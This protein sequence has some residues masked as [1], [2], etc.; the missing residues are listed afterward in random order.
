M[1]QVLLERL[2]DRWLAG[3]FTDISAEPKS[4]QRQT[5]AVTSAIACA[6]LLVGVYVYLLLWHDSAISTHWLPDT[7]YIMN[8]AWT[9]H[10]G[11][12]PNIDFTD[13][14]G[15][16]LTRLL[17]LGMSLAGPSMK[18][19]DYTLA[20][21]LVGT[22]AMLAI[23]SFRRLLPMSAI[24]ALLIV[25]ALIVTRAPLEQPF[26]LKTASYATIYNRLAWVMLF[27]AYLVATVPRSRGND[28]AAL[29]VAGFATAVML[30]T[31]FSFVLGMPAIATAFLLRGARRD[32][33]VWIVAT[34]AS[35]LAFWIA[36]GMGPAAWLRLISATAQLG[37][38]APRGAG[39][40]KLVY[41]LGYN[42]VAIAAILLV[43][44]LLVIDKRVPA[45]PLAVVTVLMLVLSMG[46]AVTTGHLQLYETTSPSMAMLAVPILAHLERHHAIGPA[47]WF[48]LGLCILAFALPHLANG[49][50]ANSRRTD[51]WGV[52]TTDAGALNSLSIRPAQFNRPRLEVRELSA[53]T[54]AS[55]LDTFPSLNRLSDQDKLLV[56]RDAIK[57]FV[58]L[59]GYKDLRIFSPGERIFPFLLG[60]KPITS[61]DHWAIPSDFTNAPN[62]P[63]PADIDAIAVVRWEL[64]EEL[65]VAKPMLR[66]ARLDFTLCRKSELWNI[67]LRRSPATRRAAQGCTASGWADLI[68]AR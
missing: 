58:Q 1:K 59:P 67:Y 36:F 21:L 49:A 16:L 41:L 7:L 10:E 20:M 45:L 25:V 6:V 56:V 63:L 42:W 26:M 44:A 57:E 52:K 22:S 29:A 53:N 28:A 34:L 11:F 64:V 46:I 40:I 32:C 17:S 37:E 5:F 39:L 23:A 51:K 48:P 50:W 14:Y 15:G 33:A 9:V 55:D 43:S 38:G 35:L 47:Y 4:S 18:A 54:L 8:A 13:R 60:S 12:V 30:L 68:P 19:L 66:R 27:L 65:P 24:A 31:K 3:P 61:V 62:D 2:Q